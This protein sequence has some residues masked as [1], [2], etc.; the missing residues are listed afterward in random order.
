MPT[1][2]YTP[3]PEMRPL[4]QEWRKARLAGRRPRPYAKELCERLGISTTTLRKVA[5]QEVAP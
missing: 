5:R 3:P 4:I 1:P 2:A